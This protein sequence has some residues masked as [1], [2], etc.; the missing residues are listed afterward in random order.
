M[1]EQRGKFIDASAKHEMKKED[2]EKL[3]LTKFLHLP[4]TALTDRILL[5]MHLLHIRLLI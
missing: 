2:A 1:E 3:Y 4:H 5:L